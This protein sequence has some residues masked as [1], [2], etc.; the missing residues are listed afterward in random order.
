MT[1][2][3]DIAKPEHWNTLT[4]VSRI[5]GIGRS[6]LYLEMAAGRL[7]SK[8]IGSARRI[9]DSDLVAWQE[10]FDSE[11]RK[12]A[13]PESAAEIHDPAAARPKCASDDRADSDESDEQF[14]PESAAPILGVAGASSVHRLIRQG[15]LRAVRMKD[16]GPWTISR[17]AIDDCLRSGRVRRPRKS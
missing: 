6:F 17:R 11:G 13:Q 12:M 16:G 4:E 10:S 9:S 1:E 3:K 7:R 5:T 2:Q 14:T 15:H 8:K